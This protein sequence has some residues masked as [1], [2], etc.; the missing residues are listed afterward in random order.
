MEEITLQVLSLDPPFA[1][2]SICLCDFQVV[3]SP[4]VHVTVR[5]NIDA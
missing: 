2:L 3:E 5:I 1:I 4:T